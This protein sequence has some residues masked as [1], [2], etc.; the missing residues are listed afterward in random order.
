MPIDYSKYP[1]NW[2]ELRAKVL[3]RANNK[4]E[5]CGLDN[6]L[7]G[8]RDL[9]RKFWT[10][11]D[12]QSMGKIGRKHKFDADNPKLFKIVLTTAHLDHDEENKKVKI[13]RLRALC[14]KCHL[15][16]DAK[17]RSLRACEKRYKN[18]LFPYKR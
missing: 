15:N 2:K 11:Q 4:C 18:T 9:N 16:Y 6:Y 1:E 13:Q 14:Q 5:F 3:K 12:I 10:E 17:E 7:I 8:S